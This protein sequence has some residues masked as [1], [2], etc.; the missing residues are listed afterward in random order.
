[1]LHIII[2]EIKKGQPII[3]D[4]L[5]EMLKRNPDERISSSDVVTK[6]TNINIE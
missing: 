1:M 2:A 5:M 6:L 4:I 3:H